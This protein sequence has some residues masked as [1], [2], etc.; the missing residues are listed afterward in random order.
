MGLMLTRDQ[1]E[2]HLATL[3]YRDGVMWTVTE[4]PWEGIKVRILYPVEDTYNPG[5]STMLG[6]DSYLSPNDRTTTQALDLWFTWRMWRIEG[7]E[8]REYVKRHGV[9]LFDPHREGDYI[10]G[11]GTVTNAVDTTRDHS[12]AT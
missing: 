12:D 5:Q 1:V 7:H 6:I 11:Y 3:D 2:A 8:A 9:P 10:S 4:D